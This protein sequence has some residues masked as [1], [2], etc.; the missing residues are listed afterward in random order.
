MNKQDRFRE[1]AVQFRYTASHLPVCQCSRTRPVESHR[2]YS[3]P[4]P[5]P[6]V[7]TAARRSPLCHPV[8]VELVAFAR[9]H[10]RVVTFAVRHCVS[11]PFTTGQR[12]PRA[13]WY[14]RTA[15]DRDRDRD[16]TMRTLRKPF[17]QIEAQLA[18]FI[19]QLIFRS[20][21]TGYLLTSGVAYSTSYSVCH[22]VPV[23]SPAA[24][25][26]ILLLF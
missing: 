3:S 8:T 9:F 19:V 21:D 14:H 26:A 22:A 1:G 7:R 10:V 11:L 2:S 25:P 24:L 17:L 5:P 6:P 23:S 13:L 15:R 20:S 18:G 4:V 12:R 16:Q